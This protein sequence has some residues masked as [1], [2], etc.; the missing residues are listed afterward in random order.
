MTRVTDSPRGPLRWVYEFLFSLNLVW[1]VVWVER[2]KS[3]L[4]EGPFV[5]PFVPALIRRVYRHVGALQGETVWDQIIWS[6][7][8]AAFIFLILRLAARFWIAGAFLRSLAGISALAAFPLAALQYPIGFL[9]APAFGNPFAIRTPWLAGEVIFILI[10]GSLYY[11]GKWPIANGLSILL[12]ILHFGLW[13]WLTGTYVN[14]FVW[15]RAYG[16][17][18][19][20]FWASAAF[21][22]GCP[23]IGFLASL[24]WGLYV[25][26]SAKVD[27]TGG[28]PAVSRI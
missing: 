5:A 15:A 13:S 2:A 9:Q 20:G 25:K 21:Y 12:L 7:V 10:C 19:L 4:P 16:R 23:V 11:L 28:L 17:V 27:S 24:T 26:M 8:L 6:I 22:W 1:A 14:L 3:K 18:S